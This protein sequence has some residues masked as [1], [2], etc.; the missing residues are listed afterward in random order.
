MQIKDMQNVVHN[1]S[2]LEFFLY[3]Y[4]SMYRPR[5]ESPSIILHAVNRTIIPRGNLTASATSER[6][7]FPNFVQ[8]YEV[9]V[10]LV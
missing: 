3:Y 2:D 9:S 5:R 6:Q 10:F 7:S 8:N 4:S 1:L